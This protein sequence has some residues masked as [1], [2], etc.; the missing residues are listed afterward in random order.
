MLMSPTYT[1]MATSKGNKS[2]PKG[3]AKNTP[4][5]STGGGANVARKGIS[6][7][8]RQAVAD[9]G[10]DDEDLELIAG[11]D[12]DDADEVIAVKGAAMDEVSSL[13]KM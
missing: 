10:G 7:E 4:R 6:E 1:T 3:A 11:V 8:L 12:N 9:L 2:A 5:P 13:V